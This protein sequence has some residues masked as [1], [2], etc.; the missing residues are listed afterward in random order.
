MEFIMV[1]MFFIA[2][3][4]LWLKPEKKSAVVNF[5]IVGIVILVFMMAW[6]NKF[7]VLPMGNF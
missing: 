4:F 1:L 7:T 2:G 3:L 5:G 6:V